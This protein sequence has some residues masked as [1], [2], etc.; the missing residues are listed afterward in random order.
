M[1]GPFLSAGTFLD[2]VNR[3]PGFK[4]FFG[5][6]SIDAG[7]SRIQCP[8]LVL[9]GTDGDV[10]NEEDLKQI[11]A[12]IKRLPTRPGRVDTSLIQGADHMYDGHED[13]VAQVIASWSDTLLSA[14]TGR[15]GAPKNP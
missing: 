5:A 7:V 1:Q 8:L 14:N 10:G 15:G 13:R 11:K 6:L 12:S 2:L 9:L 3:P 4:D